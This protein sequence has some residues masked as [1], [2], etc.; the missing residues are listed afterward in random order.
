MIRIIS[1][2]LPVIRAQCAACAVLHLGS[3]EKKMIIINRSTVQRTEYLLS[4]QIRNLLLFALCPLLFARRMEV[5]VNG[6]VEK[7]EADP[8]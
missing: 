8:G 6:L 2:P 5:T 7:V 3:Y 1:S 4:Y